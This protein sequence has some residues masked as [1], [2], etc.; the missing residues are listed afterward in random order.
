MRI[1]LIAACA[2]VCLAAAA[3]AAEDDGEKVVDRLSATLRDMRDVSAD[4]SVSTGGRQASGSLVLQYVKEPAPAGQGG[5]KTVRKYV[6]VTKMPTADGAAQVT[7]VNDG[8]VLWVERKRLD[9][10]EVKV[11]RRRVDASGPMPGGFGPDWRAEMDTW[12]RKYTWRALRD[13]TFDGEKVNVVEGVRKAE[14]EQNEGTAPKPDITTPDRI[15]LFIA[16]KD[17]FLRKADLYLKRAVKRPDGTTAA[18]MV[19][20]VSVR[21]THVKLNTG[22]APD[23]FDYRIPDGA[24]FTDIK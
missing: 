1:A 16:E 24:E 12:R 17:D 4:V 8:R 11:V 22:L 7:Q 21:L 23:A 14:V 18:S 13:D 5:E 3:W 2:L 9:T 15:V 10:G 6:L 20:A 19:L